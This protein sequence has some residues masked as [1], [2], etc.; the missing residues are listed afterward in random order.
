MGNHVVNTRRAAIDPREDSRLRR[1]MGR[2]SETALETL[3]IVCA[4]CDAVFTPSALDYG[5]IVSRFTPGKDTEVLREKFAAL[6]RDEETNAFLLRSRRR[7]ELENRRLAAACTEL[8]KTMSLTEANAMLGRGAMHVFS[9]KQAQALLE[10]CGEGTGRGWFLDVGAGCGEVTESLAGMFEKTCATESSGGMASRLRERGFDVVLESDSIQGV[11]DRVRA[12]PGGEDLSASGFDV[13]AAL[14]L[15][16][17]VD[18][19]LTLMRQLR[20]ALKPN[21]GVLILAI[22]VPFRP[23]VERADGSRDKPTE[24][25]DAPSSGSWESGVEALWLNLIKPAGFDLVRLSRVPYISEGDHKFGA[26]VLDDAVFVLRASDV[27][28][29]AAE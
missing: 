20:D 14:N 17:R 13:V 24:T 12:T 21:T 3:P 29:D 7:G 2:P 9:K 11:V 26:Y 6:E 18:A 16:D 5:A 22:V 15:V 8:R 25:V 1:L 23:F 10:S 27:Q 28:R 4:H 19:P